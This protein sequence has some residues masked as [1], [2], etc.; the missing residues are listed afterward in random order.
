LATLPVG[1]PTH[2]PEHHP[3]LTTQRQTLTQT[4]NIARSFHNIIIRKVL[5]GKGQSF[6]RRIK[7]SAEMA[8]DDFTKVGD[9][10]HA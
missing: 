9:P 4:T 5:D 7:M 3:T 8:E 6:S 10:K 1:T 2:P